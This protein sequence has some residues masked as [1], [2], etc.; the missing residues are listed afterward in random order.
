ML[1]KTIFIIFFTEVISLLILFSLRFINIVYLKLNSYEPL[2]VYFSKSHLPHPIFRKSK[3][4]YN[5]MS[6]SNL[7][8]FDPNT[9]L[10]FHNENRFGEKKNINIKNNNDDYFIYLIGGSTVDGTGADTPNETID[11]SIKRQIKKL[12]CKNSVKIFNEA[13]SGNSSKQDFLNISLRLLPHNSPD[14]ILSLQGWN[15]FLSYIGTRHN[16]ISP[17]AKY[18]TTRE[19]MTYKY[20]N[21][22]NFYKNLVLL[23]KHE[24]Y[25][26]ILLSSMLD[27]YNRYFF[28]D[29]KNKKQLSLTE[30]IEV[31]WEVQH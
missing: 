8:D 30:N 28:N 11:A 13:V 27:S 29:L 2:T 21:S 3:N 18:W 10:Y 25:L 14:M 17:L 7:K 5:A 4:E 1:K 26:G 24:T 15:D 9:V 31:F 19:Q 22:Y 20:I 16:E 23:V 6:H 12:N